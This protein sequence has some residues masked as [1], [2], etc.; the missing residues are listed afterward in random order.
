MAFKSM[1]T[2]IGAQNIRHLITRFLFVRYFDDLIIGHLS[3]HSKLTQFIQIPDIYYGSE[4]L[5][6]IRD[7][8][9]W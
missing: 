7:L 3:D 5:T 6:L 4:T 2:Y 9:L 1:I 8:K